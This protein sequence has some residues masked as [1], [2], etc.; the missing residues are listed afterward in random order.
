MD[1]SPPPTVA[2]ASSS[3]PLELADLCVKCGLCL[4]TCPTY[5]QTAHE[6]DSPRGRISLMQGLATGAL[7]VTDK[8]EAHLDGCLACRACERVCPAKV[9]YGELIDAGRSLL[10]THKPSRTRA[11]RLTGALL[12]SP[13][14]LRVLHLLLGLY[15][16]SGLQRLVRLSRILGRGRLARLESLI[17]ERRYSALPSAPA[18]TQAQ[19]ISLFTGCVGRL[20]DE[21]TLRALARLFQHMGYRVDTPAAQGCCGAIRE[22]GGLPE[23]AQENVARNLRAFENASCIVHSA[24]GCGATLVDYPRLAAD[25]AEGAAFAARLEDASAALLKRW[26][27]HL[28]LL[29]LPAR[30]AVH[31]PCTQRNV[32]RNGDQI[33][34]LLRK[35]PQIELVELDATQQCCGAAGTYFVTQPQMADQLLQ[36][37]LQGATL[38]QPDYIVSTNI[39]CS[40]HIAG[41]LRRRGGGAPEVLHPATLLARQLPP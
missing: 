12:S 4:P 23:A 41:G 10:A 5:G 1:R 19:T 26:P 29:P 27:D 39:G 2:T 28:Q 17:P 7:G 40:L 3:F 22:H 38:L 21:P 30:V 11:T 34:Q 20:V 6:G 18:A 25:R 37:K 33:L 13:S 9:P 8:L 31:M 32:L 15:R 16:S 24:S 36:R 35:I 14:G